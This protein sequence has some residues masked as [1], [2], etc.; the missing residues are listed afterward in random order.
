MDHLLG[1]TKDPSD[2][3]TSLSTWGIGSELSMAQWRVLAIVRR[4]EGCTMSLLARYSTIDRT[5]LTRAVDQLVGLDLVERWTPERDR[6]Q[7]NLAL[8]DDGEAAFVRAAD[9]LAK[10]NAVVLANVAEHDLH[11]ATQ[12]LQTALINL[13]A[14]A[15]LAHDLITFGRRPQA[16]ES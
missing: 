3:E 14:D 1:K 12:V 16:E 2:F 7:V 15:A 13:V 11:G 10:R 4:I 5:T 9:L 6:R 8:T